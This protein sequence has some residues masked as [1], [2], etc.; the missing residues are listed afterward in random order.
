MKIAMSLLSGMSYGGRTYF[1][2]LIP[3]L[4][5][6]DNENEY[7]FFIPPQYP[8]PP[9]ANKGNV[10][11]HEIHGMSQSE[12]QHILSY[13][14][15]RRLIWEQFI[16]P[17]HLHSLRID[18]IYTAKNLN[19]LFAPCKTV[20]AIRNVEPFHYRNHQND[21]KLNVLSWLKWQL[22]KFS[23]AK[24]NAVVA[25]SRNTKKLIA[26]YFPSAAQHTYVV[27]NGNPVSEMVLSS[28]RQWFILNSSKFIAYANQLSLIEGYARL[29]S[30]RNDLPPI[31]F[32][33]GVVDQTYFDKVKEAVKRHQLDEYVQFLGQIAQQELFSMYGHA[34]AFVFPS[35]LESCPHTLIEAMAY[36]VPIAASN[37]EPMPEICEDAAIYFDPTDH[38]QVA[39][40]IERICF[41]VDL[42]S[43][44]S[45]NGLVRYKHFSWQSSAQG[46]KAVIES[47]ITP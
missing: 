27:Y 22:L 45:T 41:D 18:V 47:T 13:Q 34:H 5:S 31:R 23:I 26:E 33:G 4:A 46:L 35:A 39:D 8:I 32:V 25:V 29:R 20:I 30:R 16:L 19:V 10:H 9:Q 43:Q 44:T 36:S 12:K 2:N 40:A 42:R 21:W 17:I 38:D 24:A 3:M 11:F 37:I 28:N 6:I 14:V 1:S 15:L 7:H